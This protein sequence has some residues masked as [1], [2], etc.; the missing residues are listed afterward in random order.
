M[1]AD[2]ADT[3]HDITEGDNICP[4]EYCG[5]KCKGYV[6]TKGWDPVTGLGT[7]NAARME[8]YV[9]KLLDDVLAR[10]RSVSTA[11]DA[12]ATAAPFVISR[13]SSPPK[14]QPT[15][16]YSA[17]LARRNSSLLAQA[18]QRRPA[19]KAV[20]AMPDETWAAFTP[21]AI[22][23]TNGSIVAVT[24]TTILSLRTDSFNVLQTC[25]IDSALTLGGF[26]AT[27]STAFA[28]LLDYLY[29][30][31]YINGIN[32][33]TCETTSSAPLK[34]PADL[35]SVDNAGKLA[36]TT[37]NAHQ[38][39]W[40][41][42]ATGER[43]G[44]IANASWD[45][46]TWG[47]INSANSDVWVAW[48]QIG[49]SSLTSGITVKNGD[50]TR[51]TITRSGGVETI[52]QDVIV[53]SQGKYAYMLLLSIT[54]DGGEVI[55]IEQLDATSGESLST[56]EVPSN[57]L[58]TT[59][60]ATRSERSGLVYWMSY[61]KLVSLESSGIVVQQV[62]QY[63]LI[64]LPTDVAVT[65]DGTVLVASTASNQIQAL[66]SSGQIVSSY[67]SV[68]EPEVCDLIPFLNVAVDYEGNVYMPLCNSTVLIFDSQGDLLTQVS[69][70]QGTIPRSV[71]PGP[72]NTLFFTDD[73]NHMQVQHIDR[74]GNVIHTFTLSTA[75]WL[76]TVKYN[77][78]ADSIH[79]TDV[80]KGVIYQWAVNGT[81]KPTV[82]DV[83]KAVGD[84][85]AEVYS[86]A[87][88]HHHSQLIVSAEL[89][90]IEAGALLWFDMDGTLLAKNYTFPVGTEAT[91]VAVSYDGSRV[92]ATDLFNSAVYVFYQDEQTIQKT[93]RRAAGKATARVAAD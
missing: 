37:T 49:K 26:A 50:T 33:Q 58:P 64:E 41:D 59:D 80:L 89:V 21:L 16:V 11:K 36:L 85:A 72:H 82:L 61:N 20:G 54:R 13:F 10:R 76:F 4:E 23:F 87:I 43:R 35:L 46:V 22:G 83:G 71:A 79:V 88:D 90:S 14:S 34:Y 18:Q 53:D 69:T 32:P 70:G 3:F 56:Y 52:I 27:E 62:G 2:E 48:V 81:G 39:V 91:G 92:Y 45:V 31:V 60:L 25:P 67:P 17:Y 42:T 29:G 6:A 55:T 73:N 12:A 28:L 77:W 86:L 74:D 66:N 8:A 93:E 57:L 68:E 84:P 63:P 75:G 30:N 24:E 40:F 65:A 1:Y 5:P 51:F 47:A 15:D 9:S 7:P 78:R 19:V 44:V 38:V